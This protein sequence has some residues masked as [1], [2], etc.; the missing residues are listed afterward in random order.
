MA[1]RPI[2]RSP[3]ADSDLIDIWQA[4]AQDSTRAADRLLDL[5]ADR[6]LQLDAFPD[7]GPRRPDI[8]AD[9]RA[10]TVGNYLVLY[11]STPEKIEILRIVHGARDVTTLL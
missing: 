7:S 1:E 11:R 3:A 8:A 9:A 5:I 4:I 6:I 2:V 10:L